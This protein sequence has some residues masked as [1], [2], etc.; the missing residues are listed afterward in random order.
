LDSRNSAWRGVACDALGAAFRFRVGA[1]YDTL[2]C[3][4]PPQLDEG[5]SGSPP[6]IEGDDEFE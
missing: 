6:K 3:I 2:S 1:A 5:R 4:C